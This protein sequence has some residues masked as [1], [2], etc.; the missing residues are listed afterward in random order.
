MGGTGSIS[1]YINGYEMNE[2]ELTQNKNVS[3]IAARE[4]LYVIKIGGNV[5]DDDRALSS[6]LKDFSTI[7]EKKILVHGGGSNY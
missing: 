7:A 3:A 2:L 4:T 5:I 1:E 6:F